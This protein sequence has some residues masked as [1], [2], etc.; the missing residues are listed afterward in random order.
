MDGYPN[1]M[2]QPVCEVR[3]IAFILDYLARGRVDLRAGRLSR[4]HCIHAGALRTQHGRVYLKILG[5]R[6]L[7]RRAAKSSMRHYL[8]NIQW[9]KAAVTTTPV[10]QAYEDRAVISTFFDRKND[11]Q[12]PSGVGRK[13]KR[14]WTVRGGLIRRC[15][16]DICLQTRA[17]L[18]GM[19][20]EWTEAKLASRLTIR[21][22]T[23][24]NKLRGC[25][26]TDYRKNTFTVKRLRLNFGATAVLCMQPPTVFLRIALNGR[27]LCMPRQLPTTRDQRVAAGVFEWTET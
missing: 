22:R 5:E 16:H 19:M 12:C 14:E 24:W 21:K 25:L 9:T 1:T 2:T 26:R 23:V 8:L 27:P 10:Y 17:A 4:P 15:K 3:A 6:A 18:A 13:P 11:E 20:D 7:L